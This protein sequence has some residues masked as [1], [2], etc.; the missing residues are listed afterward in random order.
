MYNFGANVGKGSNRGARSQSREWR[1]SARLRPLR[2]GCSSGW[3]AMRAN[4]LAD[5]RV[6]RA[7]AVRGVQSG[8]DMEATLAGRRPS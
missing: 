5:R 7:R 4:L 8:L 3:T 6:P 2:L 1:E